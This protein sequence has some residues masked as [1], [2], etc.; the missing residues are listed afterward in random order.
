MK[1]GQTAYQAIGWVE[2]SV[3][4][5]FT[6]QVKI[7][8]IGLGFVSNVTNVAF[9]RSFTSLGKDSLAPKKEECRSGCA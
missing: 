5:F 6:T 4:E 3:P 7:D 8:R 1:V 9:L 2:C